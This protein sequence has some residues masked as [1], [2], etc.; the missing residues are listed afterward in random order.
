MK[1]SL[2]ALVL[3][4]LLIC[5]CACQRTGHDITGDI[6][7]DFEDQNGKIENDGEAPDSTQSAPDGELDF[8]GE[9]DKENRGIQENNTFSDTPDAL[10]F[11]QGLGAEVFDG[12]DEF[13]GIC[14]DFLEALKSGNAEKLSILCATDSEV[15]TF[16]KD[17]KISDCF[18]TRFTFNSEAIEK[19]HSQ[20]K[21]CAG[22]YGESGLYAVTLTVDDTG[23]NAKNTDFSKGTSI[24]LLKV[25]PYSG[26]GNVIGAFVPSQKAESFLFISTS[27]S[28]PQKFINEFSQTYAFEKLTLGKNDPSSFDLTKEVH[29]IT[30]MLAYF[31]EEYPPYSLNRINAF[32]DSA[33]PENPGISVSDITLWSSAYEEILGIDY[34]DDSI[35]N[36][37]EKK[38]LGCSYGHGATELKHS[39][40]DITKDGKDSM[41]YT[42]EYYA[43]NAYICKAQTMKYY[44]DLSGDFPALTGIVL[45]E[46][47]PF[48]IA[49]V[50]M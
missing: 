43:D 45:S 27:D 32:I 24:W 11:I 8:S 40:T 18:A 15:F 30:H 39:V 9:N 23:S 48:E 41:V 17:L 34:N 13:Y 19:I 4:A 16:C 20:D 36:D 12:D 26:E 44:F 29:A 2:I 38:I 14:N 25:S 6:I 10:S 21:I 49:Y 35:F 47:Y 1:K 5:L 46:K 37:P 33:F 50:S 28:K 7:E 42:V 22:E 3:T 31:T